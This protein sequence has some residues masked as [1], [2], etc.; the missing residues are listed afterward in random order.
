MKNLLVS[1]LCSVLLTGTLSCREPQSSLVPIPPV[2]TTSFPAVDKVATPIPP[3]PAGNRLRTKR[4]VEDRELNGQSSQRK[5]DFTYDSFNRLISATKEWATYVVYAY[6]A[7]GTLATEKEFYTSPSAESYTKD[8]LSETTYD[9]ENGRV[10]QQSQRRYMVGGGLIRLN[11]PV[12]L[13]QKSFRYNSHGQISAQT[14]SVWATSEYRNDVGYVALAVPKFASA[15]YTAYEYN[16]RG[17]VVRSVQQYEKDYYGDFGP[18][19][20]T[21]YTYEYHPNGLVSRKTVEVY[22]N[23]YKSDSKSVFTYEY[24]AY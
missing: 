5:A 15:A 9:Y 7:D 21:T 18:V 16:D 23:R 13:L 17:Q 6:Q 24:G 10:K 4:I 1:L 14:D 8:F 11:F 22:D 20:P 3:L 12:R 19:G 2:T